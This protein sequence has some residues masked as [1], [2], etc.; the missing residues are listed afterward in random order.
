[1]AFVKI[2]IFN[3]SKLIAP[4]TALLKKGFTFEWN[5]EKEKVICQ[6]Q[7]EVNLGLLII[8]PNPQKLYQLE[9]NASNLAIGAVLRILTSDRYK[10]VAYKSQVLSKS[11][12]NYPVH[13]K[14]L[15]ALVYP[16]KKWLCYLEEIQHLTALTDHKSLK[17]LKTES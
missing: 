9:K 1:M 13:N 14:R 12:Q 2:F 17:L 16:L 8:Y 7:E 3:C 11:D 15:F 10:F 5:Y 6:A 4:L